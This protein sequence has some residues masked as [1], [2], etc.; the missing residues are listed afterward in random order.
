VLRA[1][2]VEVYLALADRIE[3]MKKLILVL[4]I[5]ALYPGPGLDP[6]EVRVQIR[7]LS[8]FPLV[9]DSASLAA[10]SVGSMLLLPLNDAAEAFKMTSVEEGVAFD[11][12]GDG[13]RDQVAWPEAGTEIAILALDVDEDGRVTSGKEIFGS[14]T[15]SGAR[16][17]CNALTRML[18]STGAPLS[19]SIRQ[20]HAL[21]EQ[22]LLWVDRNHNG[23]SEPEELRRA[24][25]AFTAIG[26][27]YTGVGWRDVHGNRMR[28]E[29]WTERRTGGPDQPA[30]MQPDEQR[31]RLRHYYEVVLASR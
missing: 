11:I 3:R 31:L 16:N 14:Q 2:D 7:R 22:L 23:V 12:D 27:G 21:Y 19:G 6:G 29:G 28:Y 20:G 17:G 9:A 1:P 15:L 5:V 24:R 8:G 18:K 13:D 26:L 30:A 10:G 4:L 25:D